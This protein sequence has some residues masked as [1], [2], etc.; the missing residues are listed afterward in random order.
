[1]NDT[2][3]LFAVISKLSRKLGYSPEEY[4][5]EKVAELQGRIQLR[6]TPLGHLSDHQVDVF[7]NQYLGRDATSDERERVRL[8]RR[9]I[10]LSEDDRT[11]LE[12]QQNDRCANCGRFLERNTKPHVDHRIPIALGGR[13]ILDNLQLLCGQCNMGKGSLPVWQVGIPYMARRLTP[14]LRYCVIARAGEAVNGQDAFAQLA[15]ASLSL[16]L[17]CRP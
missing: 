15:P 9:S 3:R 7:W 17:E 8:E 4:L 6:M 5:F 14:R 13:D 12:R 10:R 1:M 16:C 2:G 11:K